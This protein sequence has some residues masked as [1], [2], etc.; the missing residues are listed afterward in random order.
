MGAR[1]A[2]TAGERPP[3][4]EVRDEPSREALG[5]DVGQYEQDSVPVVLDPPDDAVVSGPDGQAA[6]PARR[7]RQPRL[8]RAPQ[9]P[10]IRTADAAAGDPPIVDWTAFDVTGC[11]RALRTGSEAELRRVLRRLH[12]RWWHARASSM[13]KILKAAGVL[14]SALNLIHEIVDSCRQCREWTSLNPD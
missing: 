2:R 5:L 3:R 12:L 13:H 14:T 4:Q 7:D 1:L 11:L 9:E 6:R 10:R 8:P